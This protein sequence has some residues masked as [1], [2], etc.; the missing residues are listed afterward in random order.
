M[1]DNWRA[2]VPLSPKVIWLACREAA[3]RAGLQKKISPH[4]LRH[5]L[6]FLTMSRASDKTRIYAVSG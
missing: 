6:P 2:D 3:T 1:V 5:Y 4:C